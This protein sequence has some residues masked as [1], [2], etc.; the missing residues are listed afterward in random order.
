MSTAVII[1]LLLG[2]SI[3]VAVGLVSV[4]HGLFNGQCDD[5]LN[6][7]MLQDQGAEQ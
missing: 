4:L 6:G 1:F 2:F 7:A 3:C 5:P